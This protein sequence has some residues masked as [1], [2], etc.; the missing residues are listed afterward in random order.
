VP[1]GTVVR[2]ILSQQGENVTIQQIETTTVGGIARAFIKLQSE[3]MHEIRATSE[4]AMNSQIL[5][6]NISSGQGAQISAINPTPPALRRWRR[7]NRLSR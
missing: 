1:D 6:L 3:G 4:P 2:F 5:V 7:P